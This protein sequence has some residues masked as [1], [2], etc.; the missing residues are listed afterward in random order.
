MEKISTLFG[1]K[2]LVEEYL[3][4]REFNTTVLGNDRLIVPGISEIVF[5]LP[6]D[7]PRILTFSAK[8]DEG[9]LYFEN[10]KAV[11]PA[12]ISAKRGE[13]D[14]P[15]RPGSFPPGGLPRLCPGGFPP[16]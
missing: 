2:A 14:R 6:P 8:W 5:T 7:K 11:C 12:A 16:G 9:S 15:D 3:D 10:T 4:G 13:A 1:G